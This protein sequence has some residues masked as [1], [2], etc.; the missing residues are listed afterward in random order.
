MRLKSKKIPGFQNISFRNQLFCFARRVG[1]LCRTSQVF[2]FVFSL[3]KFGN[4][5]LIFIEDSA[6]IN[7]FFSET[8]NI[9]PRQHGTTNIWLSKRFDVVLPAWFDVFRLLFLFFLFFF[10]YIYRGAYR[11]LCLPVGP[12]QQ[13]FCVQDALVMFCRCGVTCLDCCFLGVF[14]GF[15]LTF[16]LGRTGRFVYPAA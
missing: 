10:C 7:F 6:M 11:P 15:C 1:L 2:F 12:R 13:I 4:T 8:T 16:I 5:C 9:S 3:S 14:V